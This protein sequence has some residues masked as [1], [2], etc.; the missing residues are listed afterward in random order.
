MMKNC[1]CSEKV[2]DAAQ[3]GIA[4]A[5][6]FVAARI[7]ANTLQGSYKVVTGKKP[8]QFTAANA[9]WKTAIVWSLIFGAVGGVARL[10]ANRALELSPVDEDASVTDHGDMID[11]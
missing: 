4:F 5:V 3:A 8:P 11:G 10:V 9:P 7:A 6:P 1:N 2:K